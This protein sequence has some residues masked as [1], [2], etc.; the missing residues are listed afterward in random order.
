MER[1]YRESDNHREGQRAQ[2]LLSSKRGYRM[3]QSADLLSA[4]R[5]TWS[6]GAPVATGLAVG[7]NSRKNSRSVCRT[8]QEAVVAAA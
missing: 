1:L 6:E 4:D 7:R 5:D 3:E 8:R 2:A